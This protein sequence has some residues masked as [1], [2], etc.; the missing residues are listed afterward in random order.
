M[1]QDMLGEQNP[2]LRVV[3]EVPALAVELINMLLKD[4]MVMSYNWSVVKDE[5]ILSALLVNK[6]E[7]RKMGLAN[8]Q[9]PNGR[10]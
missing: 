10:Q 6:A 5:L 2:P 3:T 4:Y 8:L 1:S 7:I 9:M